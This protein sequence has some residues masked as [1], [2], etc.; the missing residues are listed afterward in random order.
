MKVAQ[1][2]YNFMSSYVKTTNNGN[3]IVAPEKCLN[4]W[5]DRFKT[6]YI[7]D[8]KFMKSG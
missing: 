2:L 1:N 4:Q 7:M 6:K 8:P 5:H 3:M